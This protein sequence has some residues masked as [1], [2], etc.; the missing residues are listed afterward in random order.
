MGSLDRVALF[1]RE[2]PGS[3]RPAEVFLVCSLCQQ[4]PRELALRRAPSRGTNDPE[5]TQTKLESRCS[6]LCLAEMQN[7]EKVEHADT[8]C[9]SYLC[10]FAGHCSLIS[11]SAINQWQSSLSNCG[12]GGGDLTRTRWVRTWKYNGTLWQ[13]RCNSHMTTD[14]EKGRGNNSFKLGKGREKRKKKV[15]VIKL[16]LIPRPKLPVKH[17]ATTPQWAWMALGN[18]R[19]GLQTAEKHGQRLAQGVVTES[20]LTAVQQSMWNISDCR[21][22]NWF[23]MNKQTGPYRAAMDHLIW[24]GCW[25]DI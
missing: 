12:A 10:N 15:F 5:T 4:R 25:E 21:W 1:F 9:H 23:K 20:L 19:W 8:G 24:E 22:W 13:K 16:T 2:K 3:M 11:R 6:S 17:F 18:K 14:T 7:N